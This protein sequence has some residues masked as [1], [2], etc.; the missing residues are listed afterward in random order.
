MGATLVGIVALL[1]ILWFMHKHVQANP[2]GMSYVLQKGGGLL[3]LVAAAFVTVRGEFAVGLPLAFM[4]FGLL[5]W[6]KTGGF[7][8]WWPGAGVSRVRSAFA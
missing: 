7:G 8:N 4:G 2:T 5:G 1:I 6:L 3:A